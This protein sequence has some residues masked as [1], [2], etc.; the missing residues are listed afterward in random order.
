MKYTAIIPASDRE[1]YM[2]DKME[3]ETQLS[4][5]QK[6]LDD[7]ENCCQIIIGFNGE[8]LKYLRSH[9]VSGKT[10][11]CNGDVSTDTLWDAL[12]A[13]RQSDVLIV[14]GYAEKLP[15]CLKNS[16][17]RKG[18]AYMKDGELVARQYPLNL[19]SDKLRKRE[20]YDYMKIINL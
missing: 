9:R 15:A 2:L 20:K 18:I 6:Q 10:V 5:I 3:E 14:T 7:D 13:C 17:P 8:I 16:D 11:L 19:L 1:N 12:L 4:L